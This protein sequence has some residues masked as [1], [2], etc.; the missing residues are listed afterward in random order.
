VLAELIRR[1][2]ESGET[3][4]EYSQRLG[5]P[6][7]TLT[8]QGRFTLGPRVVRAALRLWPDLREDALA[9][10]AAHPDNTEAAG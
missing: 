3:D 7:W 9:W 1:Q 10:L 4:A 5:I 6:T 2:Q 8:R